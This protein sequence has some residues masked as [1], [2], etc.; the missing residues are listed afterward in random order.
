[1]RTCIDEAVSG[2]VISPRETA[3]WINGQMT[4]LDVTNKKTR[5]PRVY[6]KEGQGADA[7]VECYCGKDMRVD[8]PASCSHSSEGV[9]ISYKLVVVK[10]GTT[11]AYVSASRKG[12]TTRRFS[13]RH[14]EFMPEDVPEERESGREYT[15]DESLAEAGIQSEDL[16]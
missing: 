14:K 13:R 4:T 9:Q 1:M 3:V 8:V 2:E 6:I 10:N 15:M 11:K 5:S 12:G 7:V 16:E